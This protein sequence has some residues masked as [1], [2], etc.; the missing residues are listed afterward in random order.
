MAEDTLEAW[1][2]NGTT[3]L[4]ELGSGQRR[5]PGERVAK[6]DLAIIPSAG[7]CHE[8]SP[9]LHDHRAHATV[10]QASCDET[11][12]H[13]TTEDEHLG[14]SGHRGPSKPLVGSGDDRADPAPVAIVGRGWVPRGGKKS[15]IGS[16]ESMDAPRHRSS[17]HDHHHGRGN[18]A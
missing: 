18:G 12:A 6:V 1:D 17:S 2:E 3:V 14:I 7:A 9:L 16:D 4:H 13:A 10:C 5:R 8:L 15:D 11:P